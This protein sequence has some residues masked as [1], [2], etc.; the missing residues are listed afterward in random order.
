MEY[1]QTHPQESF[2]E[3]EG[4]V[5][6]RD[7]WRVILIYRWT[8]IT[9]FII[10][11]MV[12]FIHTYKMSP[13]YKATAKIQIKVG[14]PNIVSIKEVI[15]I[16]AQY[17][18]NYHQ[19]QYDILKS[20]S[21]AKAVIDALDLKHHKEFV[22]NE[23]K[24]TAQKTTAYSPEELKA[25]HESNLIGVVR[26]NLLIEPIRNSN[27]V[28]ISYTSHDP[29]LAAKVANAFA[30][31]YIQYNLQLKHKASKEASHWLNEQVGDLKKKVKDSHEALYAYKEQNQI[32]SLEEK[33][34]IIIQ[35]LSKLNNTYIEAK[36]KRIGLETLYN[37]SQKFKSSR[38]NRRN[39]KYQEAIESLPTVIN[40]ALIQSLKISYISLLSEFNRE[41]KKYGPKHPHI[42]QI[43]SKLKVIEKKINS[44]ATK[45]VNSIKTEYEIALAQEKVLLNALNEQK[46]EALELTKKAILYNVLKVDV[47]NN[48]HMFDVVLN[49]LKET[50]LTSGLTTSN[51]RIID[52]AFIPKAP[53]K[54]NKKANL[55]LAA[56]IGLFMGIGAAFFLEYL[57]NT[58]KT[59]KDLKR[60]LDLSF[61]GL[62]PHMDTSRI[63]EVS[64]PA[65]ISLHRSQSHFNEAY[66]SLQTS[67]MFSFPNTTSK[68]ILITSTLSSEGKS[69]TCANL[70]VTIAQS[71]AKVVI[72]DGDMRK[73]RLFHLFKLNNQ[74]GLSNLLIGQCTMEEVLQKGPVPNLSIITSGHHP[75]NPPELLVSP[76]LKKVIDELKI[77]YDLIII[78][79][80]PI[81][82]LTDSVIISNIV[83]GVALVIHGGVTDSE[84]IL[85]GLDFL[86]KSNARI[87]GAIINNIDL[88]KR[89]RYYYYKYYYYHYY[90]NE[91]MRTKKRSK[92]NHIPT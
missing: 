92:K 72:I 70:A 37:Q 65:L 8:I 20:C 41:S 50:D 63:K 66:K 48:K 12:G 3:E 61:L 39:V 36:T 15:S 73:A 56:I 24:S 74:K 87:L 40:N 60:Y 35:E 25:R 81:V 38:R 80:P 90:G 58:I 45:I 78:D 82:P 89:G 27:T 29:S 54:P 49:R 5:N 77:R 33:Q 55:M 88:T 75:S 4:N 44:E 51:V 17:D 86:K 26:S 71:G 9:I 23:N 68:S 47:E 14:N 62:I 7:Y 57:D 21:M 42:I 46:K 43:D 79:S 31:Q 67:I 16:D 59:P 6:L 84:V 32:L 1:Q 30:E 83:D 69:L 11:T 22:S 18:W 13:I 52:K 10:V 76:S 85:Q 91:E 34:N 53:I 2:K 28:N 19:T 64:N